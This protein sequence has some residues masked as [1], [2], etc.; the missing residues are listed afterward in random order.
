MRTISLTYV[1]GMLPRSDYSA[2][3]ISINPG[4]GGYVNFPGITDCWPCDIINLECVEGGPMDRWHEVSTPDEH[5]A[6]A[7]ELI[8]E[9]FP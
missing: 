8:R 7:V 2:L 3:N 1:H 6:L 9:F 4:I 5:L